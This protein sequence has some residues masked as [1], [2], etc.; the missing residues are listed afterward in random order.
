MHASTAFPLSFHLEVHAMTAPRRPSC[1][2][3]KDWDKHLVP[4]TWKTL[5]A[6]AST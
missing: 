3:E 6:T 5:I 1:E 4:V 2:R